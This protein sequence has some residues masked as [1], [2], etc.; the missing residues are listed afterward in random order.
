MSRLKLSKNLLQMKFMQKTKDELD[1]EK[2]AGLFN[3][4][5]SYLTKKQKYEF[6]PSYQYFE[7]LRFGRVSYKGANVEIER[8]AEELAGTTNGSNANSAPTNKLDEVEISDEQMADYYK[9]SRRKGSTPKGGY[10]KGAIPTGA[11]PR[12]AT[13][14]GANSNNRNKRKRGSD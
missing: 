7:N 10:S 11:S 1:E 12:G 2:D 14:K 4:S 3:Q 13:P 6:E 9:E 8:L 5:H